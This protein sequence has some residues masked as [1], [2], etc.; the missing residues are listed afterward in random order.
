MRPRKPRHPS[1]EQRAPD[2]LQLLGERTGGDRRTPV[3]ASRFILA[4][5]QRGGHDRGGDQGEAHRAADR[6]HVGKTAAHQWNI[7]AEPGW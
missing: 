2:A 3:H 1:L 7:C 6:R 4:K 5:M